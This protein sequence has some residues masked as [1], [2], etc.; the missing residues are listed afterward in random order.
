MHEVFCTYSDLNVTH[1]TK[2]AFRVY[3]RS[4][5]NLSAVVELFIR[6]R[7]LRVLSSHC[8]FSTSAYEVFRIRGC[9][10]AYSSSIFKDQAVQ[11]PW[12]FDW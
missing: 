7:Y 9:Y 10:A 5:M 11:D 6:R 8:D 2:M 4:S 12:R 1:F 3:H